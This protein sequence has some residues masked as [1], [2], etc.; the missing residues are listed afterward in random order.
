MTLRGMLDVA[1]VLW[2]EEVGSRAALER[3]LAAA[4]LPPDEGPLAQARQDA[5]LAGEVFG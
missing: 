5:M 3:V 4:D 1:H 2:A